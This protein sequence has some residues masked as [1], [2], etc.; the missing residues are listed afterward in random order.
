MVP[1]VESQN[2][3]F[4][5]RFKNGDVVSIEATVICKPD[6]EVHS[7]RLKRG[8]TIVAEFSQN[9]VTGWWI[10]EGSA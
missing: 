3:V 5:I 6:E 4:H 9:E 2:R 8:K 10:T 1:T 7:Y